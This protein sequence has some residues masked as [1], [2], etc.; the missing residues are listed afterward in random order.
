MNKY[1]ILLFG[2]L[3][4]FS[5][6][7]DFLDLKPQDKVTP[8]DFLWTESDLASYAVKHYEFTTHDGYNIG[9]WKEDNHTDN[10]ATSSFDT[11][12]VPGEWKVKESYD[13]RENDPWNF[14][15]IRELNYFLEIVIP[16]YE[17]KQI[18]GVDANIRQYIGEIYFQRAWKYFG[19]LQT[20]GDFPIVKNTLPDEK[21]PL[22]EASKR[23]PRN[24]V[25]KFILSDLD[26]ALSYLSNTPLGGKNRI[27]RNAALLVKSRVALFEASW[28]TYHK[29]TN[30][31]PGGPGWPGKEF[32][33]S[34]DTDISFFLDECKK[35]ASELADQG[36]LAENID[37]E[38][39]MGN[40]YFAQFSLEDGRMSGNS[41]VEEI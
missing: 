31:V 20:F 2:G 3:L 6:C 8:E 5:S 13:K 35:A 41:L 15:A 1:I 4:G 10:Q 40:P 22:T 7:N 39:K 18:T 12:W 28:L 36:L 19:K 34:L 27:T 9:V 25:A 24:E 32:S 11:R 17:E 16:R 37:G 33:G 38:R 14:D 29:G 21:E 26:E 23:Q 30:L